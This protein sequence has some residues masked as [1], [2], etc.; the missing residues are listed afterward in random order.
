M[1]ISEG[2]QRYERYA[3]SAKTA[4]EMITFKK[5]ASDAGHKR[6]APVQNSNYKTGDTRRKAHSVNQKKRRRILRGSLFIFFMLAVLVSAVFGLSQVFCKV[7][8]V[9][10]K[11]TNKAQD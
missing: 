3:M 4:I 7:D 10:I 8:T 11:Y 6:Y 1:E 2:T 9:T 5:V